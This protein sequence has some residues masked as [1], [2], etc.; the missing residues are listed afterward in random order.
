[1]ALTDGEEAHRQ[2][3][4]PT[5]RSALY[6]GGA[7]GPRATPTLAAVGRPEAARRHRPRPGD[8]AGAACC[9]TSPPRRST[10]SWSAKCSR[11]ARPGRERHDDGG[12]HARDGL[13]ARGGRPGGVHGRRR[14]RRGGAAKD[15]IENPQHQRTR[16]SWRAS[17]TPPTWRRRTTRTTPT[18]SDTARLR[19]TTGTGR[20]RRGPASTAPPGAG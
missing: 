13:R 14:D 3:S 15:V 4:R 8:G 1:M 2:R 16:S 19:I 5:P 20:C 10:R 18:P 7:L 12:R 9:S 6:Q 17:S 11:H